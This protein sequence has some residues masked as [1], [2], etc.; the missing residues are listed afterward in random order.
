LRFGKRR[1]AA[2]HDCT[3]RESSCRKRERER[4]VAL[5][6]FTLVMPLLLLLVISIVDFGLMFSD[7]MSVRQGVGDGG[8]QAAV[9]RF[10]SETC[11]PDGGLAPEV[12]VDPLSSEE[13]LI[14]LIKSR[15]NVDDKWTRVRVMVG[16]VGCD[17]V[18]G[19]NP[20]YA[21]GEPITICE[22]YQMKSIAAKMPKLSTPV[23]GKVFTSRA[24][25]RVET[26][27]G[28]GLQTAWE[29]PLKSP[30]SCS[31]PSP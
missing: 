8:R 15:D 3:A 26:L 30:W 16:E 9:G 7:I 23:E 20:C 19:S 12:N 6:E 10:G 28:L 22:Q 24:V 4:G 31:A 21:A 18:G 11:D 17:P 14:C 5:V 1:T 27:S 25:V 2:V 13:S 29:V